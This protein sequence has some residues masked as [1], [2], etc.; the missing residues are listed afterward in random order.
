MRKIG[1]SD[2]KLGSAL[3][4]PKDWPGDVYDYYEYQDSVPSFTSNV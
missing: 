2:E 4:M 1:W 3:S